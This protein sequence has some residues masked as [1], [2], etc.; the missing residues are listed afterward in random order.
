MHT[1]FINNK[2]RNE[3]LS[4][5]RYVIDEARKYNVPTPTYDKIFRVLEKKTARLS[6]NG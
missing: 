3:L 6:V 5:T 4:L 2:S 1:D